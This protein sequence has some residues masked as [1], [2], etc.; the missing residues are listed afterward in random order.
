MAENKISLEQ[1]ANLITDGKKNNT[2]DRLIDRVDRLIEVF[3]RESQKENVNQKYLDA[4]VMEKN[5]L[6]SVAEAQKKVAEKVVSQ[7][8]NFYGKNR[9]FTQDVVNDVMKFKVEWV[10]LQDQLNQVNKQIEQERR[11]KNNDQEIQHLTSVA[12]EID[13]QQKDLERLF[14]NKHGKGTHA[15]KA[16]E[17]IKTDLQTQKEIHEAIEKTEDAHISNTR[18]LAIAQAK[19]NKE[20]EKTNETWEQ[21]KL[22]GR[23][24]W[25]QVKE[26]ASL[27]LK[28]NEQ[29]ISDAKRLGMTSKAEAM[30]YTKNLIENAKELSRNFAMTSDQAM[31]LQESYIKVTGRATMLSKSQMSDIAASSKIMGEETVQ[32]AIKIMDSMGATSQTSVEL[33]DRNYAR[34]KNA[35]LDVTKASEELVKNLSLA[36]KLNFRSG[37]DGISKMTI[38][39]QRIRMDLQQVANVAEKF[40]TIE[41]AIEGSARLQMLGGTAA[42][43]GNNPMAM[44]YEAMADPEALFERMGKMFSTQAYFDKKTGEAR[45]DPV[46]QQLMREQAK[47]LGMDPEQAI[48]S[49]KQQAKLRSIEGDMRMQNPPLFASMDENQR[50]AIANKAEYSKESGWTVTYYDS[51]KEEQVTAAVNRLTS[52]QLEKITKDNKEPIDDI[53]DRVREIA[54][55]LVGTKERYNSMVD[56]FRMGVAQLFHPIMGIGDATMTAV[57][58]SS[59]WG[60]LTGGGLGS[61]GGLAMTGVSALLQYKLTKGAIG[62]ARDLVGRFG[63]GGSSEAST[64]ARGGGKLSK[65]GG[66]VGS[67]KGNKFAATRAKYGIERNIANNQYK[68]RI[69][70][71]DVRAAKK[72][73]DAERAAKASSLAKT[74]S[75][76]SL[77]NLKNLKGLKAGGIT[78]VGTEL[79]FAGLDYY[80]AGKERDVDNERL[81][82]MAGM[83]N[84]ITGK[85]RFSNEELKYQDITSKNK[86][87][88]AKGGAI[89]QGVGAA[90]GTAIGSIGGPIG[91]A[92]GAVIGG[93]IGKWIG[94]KVTPE[95]YEGLV[96]EHLKQIN[97]DGVKDNLRK[98]VLPVESIDY[99]VSLI[100]NQL[101]ILSATPARGNVYL[102]AEAAG[103]HVVEAQEMNTIG[104]NKVDSNVIYSSQ[105]YEPKGPLTLNINGSIDLNMKGSHIGN[106]SASDFKKM[107]DSNPELQRQVVELITNR[108]GRN[109]NA[110]RNNQ[111]NVNLRRSTTENVYTSGSF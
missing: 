99:N 97:K 41:G 65:P 55:E 31:K 67:F 36:N 40:S 109:G 108:Q 62:V 71:G 2:Y 48:Q 18:E 61:L 85:S 56:Q 50:N 90:I 28:F 96:G 82:S 26:G 100:A 107:W 69:R 38:Y 35:G 92:A 87:S 80:S 11:G 30:D 64:L 78:A 98:I 91:M 29:A 19:Y 24:V 110:G 77:K 42:M 57:N 81:S 20:L 7:L 15:T 66:L 70:A 33:L 52:E 47:A 32:G 79:L 105:M 21:V 76:G 95:E 3:E 46:Q 13:S 101:G 84:A 43:Y 22:V 51:E 10:K 34:A 59:A 39:S 45:I 44:M 83:T 27:W 37:V 14:E 103:E 104:V 106:I 68:G 16:A 9:E 4:I 17:S 63:K 58:G 60:G 53:R 74:S 72:I 89:G 1:V 25:H 5:R 102:D 23:E 54:K 8:E 86:E 6:E 73:R 111:E 93:Y 75:L 88:V 49:A 12:K 94:K